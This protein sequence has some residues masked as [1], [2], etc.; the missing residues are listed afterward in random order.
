MYAYIE[1]TIKLKWKWTSDGSDSLLKQYQRNSID[2]PRIIAKDFIE[3]LPNKCNI[4]SPLWAT[5][6]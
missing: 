4:V 3:M 5:A 6:Y 1:N 2:F